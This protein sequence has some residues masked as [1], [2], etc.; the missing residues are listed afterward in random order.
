MYRN[1]PR[2][3]RCQGGHGQHGLAVKGSQEVLGVGQGE[4]KIPHLE[5]LQLEVQ[6]VAG[7]EELADE[8]RETGDTQ[9]P[10][11]LEDARWQAQVQASPHPCLEQIE[12]GERVEG[13]GAQVHA[14]TAE[15]DGEG[16]RYRRPAGPLSQYAGDL[17]ERPPV[18]SPEYMNAVVQD[19][20]VGG[21]GGASTAREGVSLQEGY[22]V[23][24]VSH[25]GGEGGPARPGAYDHHPFSG[26]VAR[27]LYIRALLRKEG[28]VL[29]VEAE[30][31]L[32]A[33]IEVGTLRRNQVIG[34]GE[35]LNGH[36]PRLRFDNVDL[37]ANP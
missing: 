30:E 27:R 12:E 28:I 32:P 4:E 24:G 13:R 11:G 35:H 22:L 14:S 20:P 3:A 8:G 1:S 9:G 10:A 25:Q 36:A 26:H 33:W 6:G 7:V 17:S 15:V 21:G 29:V 19:E 23:A 16:G 31:Q 2:L 5:I 18:P 37:Y 34:A